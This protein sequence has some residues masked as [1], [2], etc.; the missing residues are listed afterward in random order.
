MKQLSSYQ[1]TLLRPEHQ[2]YGH[3]WDSSSNEWERKTLWGVGN[4]WALAGI[5][6]V[7][8][9]IRNE[10]DLAQYSLLLMSWVKACLAKILSYQRDD[11][12]F[13]DTLDDPSTF[14]D[15]NVAQ[16]VAYTIFRLAQMD[17]VAQKYVERAEDIRKAVHARVDKFGILRSVCG[18]PTFDH[19]G[20]ASV[21]PPSLFWFYM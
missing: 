17:N 13:H 21:F 8:N 3:I 12:L 18:S 15:A 16:Q 2:L 5:V 10:E 14:V 1:K 20:T 6:R 4:G 9:I 11:H 19:S 7:L